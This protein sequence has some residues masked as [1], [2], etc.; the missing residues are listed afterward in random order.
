M[1]SLGTAQQLLLAWLLFSATAGLA[2]SLAVS[3]IVRWTAQWAPAGR[4]RALV[5]LAAAPV[6]LG[7]T[8]LLSLML[9]SLLERISSEYNHCLLHAEHSHFCLVHPSDHV[10]QWTGWLLITAAFGW[11]GTRLLQQAQGL[12]RASQIVRQ[13]SRCAAYD[14]TRAVWTLPSDEPVCVCI[15][16]LHPRLM[17]SRGLLAKTSPDELAIMSAHEEAHARRKDSLVR[18]VVRATSLLLFPAHRA[19]LLSTLELAAERACD[20]QAVLRTGDRLRVAETILRVE[21]ELSAAQALAPSPLIAGFGSSLVRERVEAMLEPPREASACKLLTG[22]L[23]AV[24]VVVL[25]AYDRLHHT[26][27]ALLATF[28]H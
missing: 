3:P 16:L 19:Q 17:I 6:T 23:L 12:R 26:S 2:C 22:I 15:G 1:T 14:A 28:S 11:L 10:G 20:E 9:P 21:R 27:E 7:L 18:V 25:S 24:I 13:L 5:L 4:H 8:A